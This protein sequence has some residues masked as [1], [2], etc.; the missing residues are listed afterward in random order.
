MID[1]H[2]D[3]DVRGDIY[4]GYDIH[5]WGSAPLQG[6][7]KRHLIW[8]ASVRPANTL[9]TLFHHTS[10]FVVS[11]GT[12]DSVEHFET[13]EEARLHILAIYS[14]EYAYSHGNK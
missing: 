11:L 12:F 8:F 1:L 4:G 2:P 7:P 14:L 3:L 10:G 13:L 5:R 9:P 6:L